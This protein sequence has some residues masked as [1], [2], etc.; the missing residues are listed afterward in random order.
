[1]SVVGAV[2]ITVVTAPNSSEIA[3]KIKEKEI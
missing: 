2:W 1:M 3:Y